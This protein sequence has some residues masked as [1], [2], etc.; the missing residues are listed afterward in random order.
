MKCFRYFFSIMLIC[1]IFSINIVSYAAT[2]DDI[3]QL[4]GGTALDTNDYHDYVEYVDTLGDLANKRENSIDIINAQERKDKL[5][6]KYDL[7]INEREVALTELTTS[8]R[9]YDDALDLIGLTKNIIELDTTLKTYNLEQNDF[10]LENSAETFNKLNAKIGNN[11]SYLYDS[12]NIGILGQCWPVD[13]SNNFILKGY[14]SI[15]SENGVYISANKSDYVYAMYSGIVTKIEFS[16]TYGNWLEIQSGKGLSISYSFLQKPL[17][18][19]GEEVKQG[20]IIATI[21]NQS[22]YIETILDTEYINPM[23]LLGEMGVIENNRWVYSNIAISDKSTLLDFSSYNFTP[24]K[25]IWDTTSQYNKGGTDKV[26]IEDL[27]Q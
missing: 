14:K 16:E 3:R 2:C 18:K 21:K 23:L 5:Y 1:C 13:V 15:G 19:L 9:N 26:S 6:E 10:N 4:Y 8:M 25:K 22:L 11:R 20:D 12:Y 24:T 7:L 27:S 17:V